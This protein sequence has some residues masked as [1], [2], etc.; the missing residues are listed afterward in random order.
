[1]GARPAQVEP[2]E[3]GQPIA[4]VAEERAPS[5]KLVESMLALHGVPAAETVLE[6]ELRRGHDVAGGDSRTRSLKHDWHSPN[7]SAAD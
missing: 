5:E 7:F 1:M 3:P 2:A 4:R 6:L